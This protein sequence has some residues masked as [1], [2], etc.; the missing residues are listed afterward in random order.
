MNKLMCT[1][2]KKNAPFVFLLGHVFF[3][4]VCHCAAITCFYSYYWHTFCLLF[5]LSWS[6]WNAAGYYMDYFAQRYTASL[7]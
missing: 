6:L 7:E 1:F 3:W 4:F 5:W 2:G